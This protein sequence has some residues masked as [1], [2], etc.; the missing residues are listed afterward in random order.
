MYI[1]IVCTYIERLAIDD[2]I[3]ISK[4]FEGRKLIELQTGETKIQLIN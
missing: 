4:N 1:Y 2:A 3:D